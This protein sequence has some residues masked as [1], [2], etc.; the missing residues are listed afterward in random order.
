MRNF[1]G[2]CVYIVIL[3]FVLVTTA[4][5]NTLTLGEQSEVFAETDRYRVRFE[6]G[7]LVHFHNK[8]TNETYTL[9]PKDDLD[10][11]S[12]ISIQYNEG[13]YG[14][15]ILIDEHWEVES[16]IRLTPLSVEVAYYSD[17]R[18]DKTV[19]MRISIDAATGDLVIQQHG[20]SERVVSIMWG[21]EH[22]DSRQIDVI[23]PGNCGEIV[24]AA[25]DAYKRGYEYPE[26]WEAQL[27]I[28]QGGDGGFFCA[29]H[30]Y[31]FSVQ[32]T[33]VCTEWRTFR[34]QFS[35]GQSRPLR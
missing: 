2:K 6:H 15:Y 3:Q 16:K 35:D 26:R 13:E 12:G 24:D 18:V 20:T 7:V 14:K 29:Q 23:V 34:H 22:L 5:A 9:P 10:E 33:Q 11:Q 30:R 21:C 27:A 25:T 17:Y 32:K 4:L 28:L 8:L 31:N 19:R 1:G